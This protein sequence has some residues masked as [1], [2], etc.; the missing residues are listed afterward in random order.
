MDGL[1]DGR[2]VEWVVVSSVRVLRSAVW[3][4]GCDALVGFS[5]S[6]CLLIS[7]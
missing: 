2:P 1:R 7:V 5:I 3:S 4:V 6:L